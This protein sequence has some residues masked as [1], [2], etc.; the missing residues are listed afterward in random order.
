MVCGENMSG[1]CK[2]ML[3][4][5]NDNDDMLPTPSKWCDL[6]I[7]H[8]DVSENTFR[9]KGALEGPCNYAMNKNVENLDPLTLPPDMVLLFETHPGWNQSG[10]PEILTTDNHQG[11]GCNVLFIDSHVEFVKTKDLDDLKWKPE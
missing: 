2:A 9:C 7:E 1:I 5:A 8:C 6:L 10:G 4:Y 3:I 11:D